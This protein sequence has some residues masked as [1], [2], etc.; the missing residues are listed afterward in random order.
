MMWTHLPAQDDMFAVFDQV[1]KA[2]LGG[3]VAEK[4]VLKLIRGGDLLVRWQVRLY[5]GLQLLMGICF[6]WLSIHSNRQ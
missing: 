1:R 5:M 6:Y 4:K 3:A 2:G